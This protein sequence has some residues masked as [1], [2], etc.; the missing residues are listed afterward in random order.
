MCR[1]ADVIS[2]RPLTTED[3]GYLLVFRV[4]KVGRPNYKHDEIKI[5]LYK[6]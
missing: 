6:L 1:F 3:T 4:V 2:K 5:V